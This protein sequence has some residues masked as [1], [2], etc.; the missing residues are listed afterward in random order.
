MSCVVVC[1]CDSVRLLKKG[2]LPSVEV[3][4]V[5]VVAVRVVLLRQCAQSRALD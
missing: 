2:A 3:V 4:V 5:V 1:V